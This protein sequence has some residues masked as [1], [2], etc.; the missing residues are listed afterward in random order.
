M[1]VI[2]L[3]NNRYK[4]ALKLHTYRLS[5]TSTPY[6]DHVARNG[7]KGTKHSLIQMNNRILYPFEP[8]SINF[9]IIAQ[10][11]V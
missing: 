8:I 2:R 3:V 9:S 5:N 1:K 10:A 7:A 6:N 11:S 4:V